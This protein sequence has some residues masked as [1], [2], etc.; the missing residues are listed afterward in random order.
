MK[1]KVKD[2]NPKYKTIELMLYKNEIT[3]QTIDIF[4]LQKLKKM[5][6]KY[7]VYSYKYFEDTKSTNVIIGKEPLYDCEEDTTP[8]FTGEDLKRT[9]FIK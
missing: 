3:F 5:F 6:G 2:F 8:H 1:V 7:C 4:K 9:G